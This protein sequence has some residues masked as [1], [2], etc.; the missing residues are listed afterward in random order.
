M[1]EVFLRHFFGLV[2]IQVSI[3]ELRDSGKG[4]KSLNSAG[5]LTNFHG[6]HA[7]CR[8]EKKGKGEGV[9]CTLCEIER[10]GAN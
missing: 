5:Q 6:L 9:I 2:A 7:D 1:R 8:D 10:E 4:A 3:R